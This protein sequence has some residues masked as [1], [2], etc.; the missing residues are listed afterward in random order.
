MEPGTKKVVYTNKEKFD[1]L[2]EKIP[3]LKN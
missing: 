2:A 3:P 1:H